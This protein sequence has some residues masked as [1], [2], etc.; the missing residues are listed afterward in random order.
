[1]QNA[2]RHLK[3]D[4]EA[5]TQRL[6]LAVKRAESTV[7]RERMDGVQREALRKAAKDE[8]EKQKQGKGNWYL[9][10]GKWLA[11]LFCIQM[12]TLML[13]RQRKNES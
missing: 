8:K 11:R 12:L 5:E 2:P 7:N 3:D 1:M 13:K 9:K 6:E 4:Y 10:K